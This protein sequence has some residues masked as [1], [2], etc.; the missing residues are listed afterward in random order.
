LLETDEASKVALAA[1]LQAFVKKNEAK[2]EEEN[3]ANT[4]E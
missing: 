4:E 2:Y 3:S 1:S